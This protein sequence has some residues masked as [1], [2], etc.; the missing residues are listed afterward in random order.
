MNNTEELAKKVE[1]AEDTAKRS[2]KTIIWGGLFLLLLFMG[3]GWMM[4]NTI[5]ANAEMSKTLKSTKELL[6]DL[7][8]RVLKLE[9]EK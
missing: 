4:I 8:G 1:H 7:E 2:F 6:I 3:M 9:S 5:V